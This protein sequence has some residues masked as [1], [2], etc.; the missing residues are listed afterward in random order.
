MRVKI[1]VNAIGIGAFGVGDSVTPEALVD[2]DALIYLCRDVRSRAYVAEAVGSYRAGAYRAAIVTLWVAVVFDFIHKLQELELTGDAKAH[3]ILEEFRKFQL[4]ADVKASWDFERKVLERSWKEFELVS[5][6]EFEDLER[7]LADRNRCAHPAMSTG[8]DVYAPSAELA[9]LHIR[10]AVLHLLQHPP[11]QGQ[12]ALDRLRAEVMSEYF[13]TTVDAA[14]LH[15]KQ[16]PLVRPR[17]ALIRNFALA[18]IKHLLGP[19][20]ILPAASRF[21]AALGALREMHPAVFEATMTEKLSVLVRGALLEGR[22]RS[23]LRI[24]RRLRGLWEFLEVDVQGTLIR[25]VDSLPKSALPVELPMA[26]DIG[27]LVAAAQRRVNS[28]TEEELVAVVA[29]RPRK[30]MLARAITLYGESGSYD[31]ANERAKALILPMVPFMDRDAVKKI[32]ELAGG[33]GE[34]EDSFRWKKV[35]E[36]MKQIEVVPEVEFDELLKAHGLSEE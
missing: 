2:L 5:R 30:E 12:A 10:N 8:D 16:G 4:A 25:Y 11:V 15:F 14:V 18:N 9:R 17:A 34:I 35:V 6:H 7:L 26:F 36:A 29:K 32:I 31:E 3:T 27:E 19:E 1:V 24:L 13:P 33:N 28:A 22:A 23:V 21:I 20:L